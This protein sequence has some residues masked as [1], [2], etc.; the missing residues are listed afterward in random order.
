MDYYIEE[1]DSSG[2]YDYEEFA[3]IDVL[4][5]VYFLFYII[6]TAFIYVS[7][8]RSAGKY[9]GPKHW[10]VL[11]RVVV[12]VSTASIVWQFISG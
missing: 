5:L 2:Q 9:Q 11:A 10:A 7:I 12:V 4:Y 6:A 1:L 8:W 3:V